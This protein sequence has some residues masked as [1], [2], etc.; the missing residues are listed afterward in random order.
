MENISVEDNKYTEKF[1]KNN[2]KY[3]KLIR[4]NIKNI[5]P[6][7]INQQPYKIKTAYGYKYKNKIIYEYKIKLNKYTDCRVAYIHEKEKIIVFYISNI[8]I[9]K[10]FVRLLEKVNGVSI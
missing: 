10:D 1:L 3:E 9:K 4:D 7:L 5:L 2:F 6:V 8:I